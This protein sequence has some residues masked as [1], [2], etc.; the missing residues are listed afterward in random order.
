MNDD[1]VNVD[2]VTVDTVSDDTVTDY[3]VTDASDTDISVSVTVVSVVF[4][5][6]GSESI[7]VLFIKCAGFTRFTEFLRKSEASKFSPFRS[8]SKVL[9]ENMIYCD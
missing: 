9:R 8:H 1:K 6:Q 7:S 4:R 2:T 5:G 3:I